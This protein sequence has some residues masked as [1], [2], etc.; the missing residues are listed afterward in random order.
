MTDTDSPYFLQPFMKRRARTRIVCT[1]GPATGTLPRIKRLIRSGMSVGRLNLSHGT[2]DEHHAYVRMLRD[3]AEQMGTAVGI[4]ADLPGPKYRVGEMEQDEILLVTGRHFVLQDRPCIGSS[5]RAN[6]WPQGLHKDIKQGSQV[7]IDEG[8]VEL[9]VESV[10]G[11]DIHFRVTLGGVI[12][13]NKAV[14][15]PGNTSTLDYFTSETQEALKF[16]ESSDIDF[17]GL[18]YVR[19]ADDMRRVRAQLLKAGKTPQLV[20]KI[21][22]QQ[23]V[24]NLP[25][26]LDE[27]DAIMVARGDLGVEIPFE[28]VPAVQ[29]RLIRMANEAGKPVITATQML[30][31]M[32]DQPLPTRAEATDVYN[33]VRDGTDAI[34]LSGETSIGKFPFRAVNAMTRIAKRAESYLEYPMLAERHRAAAMKGGLGVDDAIAD[35]AVTTATRLNA[36]AIVAF[37]ESGSTAGRVASYR[38][39]VP[40]FA[41]TPDFRGG[42]KLALRWGVI[43][44]VVTQFERVQDMFYAGSQLALETKI[45]KEGDVI[46][47]VVGLPIG[48]PGTTNLLRVITLP[49]PFDP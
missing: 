43:P 48:V 1:I 5:E 20:A 9:R 14:T 13:P 36:K 37:T 21:E 47:A 22:I 3:A 44:V 45:A 2:P 24:D 41:L 11:T 34:M 32:I 38:P 17:V 28:R 29:K 8:V 49:E 18:S 35:G 30:E 23:A 6:V 26:I 16:V 33:A 15:A 42:A 39:P 40:L 25:E 46:V 4:L 12:K 10:Q 19:D 31:S 27:S 7:L